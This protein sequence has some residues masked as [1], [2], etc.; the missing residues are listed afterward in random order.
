MFK[1]SNLSKILFGCLAVFLT[2]GSVFAQTSSLQN[3][4]NNSFKKFKLAHL[5][6]NSLA[7]DAQ[8]RR[9]ITIP[10]ATGDYDLNLMPHDLRT[11]NYRAEETSVMGN[12]PL[13]RSAV[14]TFKGKIS[15]ETESE[16]RL[17]IDGAKIEGYF[18]KANGERF[19]IEPADH[20]SKSAQAG[21]FVVFAPKDSLKDHGFECL[22]ELEEK[23]ERGKEI[24]G[25]RPSATSTLRVLEIATEADY[26]F[27]SE[28]GGAAQANNE[29]LSIL[30][31]IEGSYE[32]ELGLS[33]DVVFQHAWT[34][35]DP[36]NGSTASVILNNFRNYWN[37][38]Y[39]MT[40]VPRDLAHIW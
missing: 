4:L 30:N 34:T 19:F 35:G 26:S 25:S 18:L 37:T 39:P 5:D 17:T 20:Y 1:F 3:D 10:T 7:R 33:I 23:I 11:K 8:A 9:T 14:T 36:F 29:V 28:L 22:S 16:V 21:D 15:G 32:T 27:V 13:E 2:S 38:N 12:F 31:M 24:I 40:S 6:T